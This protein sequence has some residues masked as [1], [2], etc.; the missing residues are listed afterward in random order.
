VSPSMVNFFWICFVCSGHGK[1][2]NIC[3]NSKS[4]LH[5]LRQ[6]F[7]GS[8]R[9]VLGYKGQKFCFTEYSRV[10]HKKIRNFA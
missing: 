10:G 5:A 9:L 4:R 7:S 1:Q 6:L 2:K 3:L 8:A